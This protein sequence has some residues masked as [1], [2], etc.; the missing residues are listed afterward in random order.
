VQHVGQVD[1]A[2]KDDTALLCDGW[3]KA[4][5]CAM[6]LGWLFQ[7]DP[8]QHAARKKFFTAR[9]ESGRLIGFLSASPMPERVGWY[10]EDVIR[11]P[12][13]PVG[14]AD[15]LVVEALNFLKLEGARLAT[16][17]TSPLAGDGSVSSLVGN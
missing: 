17:G 8:F 3:L 11:L 16:L 10:L 5:R 14:T 15:L 9:D 12:S 6:R 4:R 1:R 13:A 7:L 2:L